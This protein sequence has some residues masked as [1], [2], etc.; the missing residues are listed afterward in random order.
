MQAIQAVILE[1]A[2]C[3]AEFRAADFHE[4]AGR[5]SGSAGAGPTTGSQAYWAFVRLLATRRGRLT[6]PER[7]DLQKLELQAVD[8]AQ[9]YEDVTVA[10]HQLRQMDIK[11]LIASS[12]SREA[13]DHFLEK[14]S[15]RELFT[16][17]VTRDEADGVM[18]QPLLKAIKGASLDP[19]G[20]IYLADTEEGLMIGKEVGVNAMLMINDHDEG[21]RLAGYNPAGGIVSLIELPDGLRLIAQQS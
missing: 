7:K 21:H 10:L 20:T 3:L 5:L 9:L 15:L 8:N 4:A 6:P 2:G 11:V 14:F 17:S 1:P 13:V 18:A 12:L 16:G 19:A